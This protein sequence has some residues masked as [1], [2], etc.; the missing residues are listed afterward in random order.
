MRKLRKVEEDALRSALEEATH[1][2][3]VKRLVM[4]LAY[5]DDVSVDTLSDRYGIPRS[6]IYTWLDRFETESIEDA[7]RDGARPGRP[8]ALEPHAF[9]QLASDI[10]DGPPAHG[11]STDSWTANVLKT[12]ISEAYGAEYS[13]GHARRLLRQL[14]PDVDE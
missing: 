8:P 5:L 13:E 2:K 3:A 10:A 6:T 4:A 7:I 11:F 14:G 1:P 9:V 12:H